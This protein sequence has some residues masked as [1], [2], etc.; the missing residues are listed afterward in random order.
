VLYAGLPDEH[1][2]I[3][4]T[5]K[6]LTLRDVLI[7]EQGQTYLADDDGDSDEARALRPL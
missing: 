5:M 2:I 7:E 6:L 3:T 1:K 4:R